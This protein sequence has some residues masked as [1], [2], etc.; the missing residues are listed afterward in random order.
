MI[1]T[2]NITVEDYIYEF[3]LQVGQD[4]GLPAEE[5]MSRALFMYTYLVSLQLQEYDKDKDT[6]L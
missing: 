3:Y 4:M 1:I 2:T 5:V 6:P